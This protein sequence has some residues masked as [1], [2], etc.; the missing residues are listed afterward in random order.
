MP[1]TLNKWSRG[2]PDTYMRKPCNHADYKTPLKTS[3]TRKPLND[4]MQNRTKHHQN[5]TTGKSRCMVDDGE[6]I[7]RGL[8]AINN[9]TT[10]IRYG[11]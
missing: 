3:A 1:G 4:V 10:P 2:E 6:P 11:W 5:R 9:A 7:D 8:Q